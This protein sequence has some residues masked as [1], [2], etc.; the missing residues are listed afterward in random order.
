MVGVLLVVRVSNVLPWNVPPDLS[1]FF[2]F[3]FLGAAT[4]FWHGLRGGTW[5]DAI[6]QLAG[7]LAY[8]LVLVVPLLGRLP[9]IDVSFAVSLWLYLAIIVSSAVLAT[10][11]LLLDP[12]WRII[13]RRRAG[14]TPESVREVTTRV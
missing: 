6:G 14:A 7:F 12:R 3:M 4:Y 11:Y 9:S 1:T 8:D 10:W 13:G 5:D 2:G